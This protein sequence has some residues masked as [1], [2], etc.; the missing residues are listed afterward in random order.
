MTTIDAP[1]SA[2]VLGQA[3]LHDVTSLADLDEFRRWAGERRDWLAFDT[4]SAGL[5]PYA[6]KHRKTQLGDKHHGWAFAPE[7]MGGAHEVLGNYTGP[8]A[9][10]NAPYD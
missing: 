9:A 5:S 7:W 3:V 1:A 10:F 6:D 4:E 2:G 8:L